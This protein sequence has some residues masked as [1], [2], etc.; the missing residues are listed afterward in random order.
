MSDLDKVQTI[1]HRVLLGLLSLIAIWSAFAWYLL[2]PLSADDVLRVAV[3]KGFR[4]V[5]CV[6]CIS[7][8]AICTRPASA[9]PD[10]KAKA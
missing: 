3:L 10:L 5:V 6:I 9:G 1:V 4:I 8:L 2:Q 7:A